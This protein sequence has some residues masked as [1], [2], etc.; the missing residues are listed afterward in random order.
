VP[1]IVAGLSDVTKVYGSVRA[2]Q[3]VD[4]AFRRG[5]I[6]A[7]LGENGSGKSTA[8]KVLSGAV[9]PDE[10]T[11]VLDGTPVR[12]ASPHD[13]IAAGIATAYQDS[14]LVPELTVAENLM[15]AHEPS[16]FGLMSRGYTRAARDT[17]RELGFELDPDVRV[18]DLSIAGRQLTAIAKA[19]MQDAKLLILDE[20]TAA[21]GQQ[22]ADQ[23][24]EDLR[25][26]RAKGYAIVY[27]SHRL[28]EIEQLADRV[29]VL[30]D[31]RVVTSKVS[32]GVTGDDLIRLMVGREVGDLFPTLEPPRDEVAVRLRDV[33]SA[34][35]EI[36]VEELELR[37]GEI[38][39]L[40]GLEGSGRSTLARL[41]AGVESPSEG[42][43]E[44]P[45]AGRRRGAWSVA[46]T[47]VPPD[48]RLAVIPRFSVERTMSQSALGL[49]TRFGMVRTREEGRRAQ[50]IREQIGVKTATLDHGITTLSGGNQQKAILGRC[51]F[52][53]SD[54]LVCD[55]P[56]AGVDVGARA[57]IY[58]VIA[59]LA[60]DGLSVLLSSSDSL[61]LLGMCHRV[62]VV[63]QGQIVAEFASGA[64]TEEELMRV[65]LT[66]AP[67]AV[68]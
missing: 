39:G 29:T 5:E 33:A 62:L 50:R 45:G 27:I 42:S 44:R 16:R 59:S 28:N 2:L 15:L 64:V 67:A 12:F 58:G 60:A 41:V 32:A 56:T 53:G 63:R 36:A 19:V 18:G 1:D 47:F 49:V 66:G 24:F 65:Q 4:L 26:L 46:T 21:L 20:P 11:V 55:E 17:L 6:H 25:R 13:A 8:V 68:A 51:L 43:V 48:R 57:E 22:Q 35:G 10:G 9:A 40:A 7:L 34:G 38:V 30:K 52:A 3:N 37:A 61:E 54:V 31:G 23:L 14:P